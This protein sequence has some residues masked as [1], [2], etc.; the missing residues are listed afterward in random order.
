MIDEFLS[1]INK[2]YHEESIYRSIIITENEEEAIEILNDL[3]QQDYTIKL[4]LNKIIHC[5]YNN[6]NERI[7]IIPINL[8]KILIK[9]IDKL[10]GGI[11]N[12]SYN[13]I[14][15]SYNIKKN[16]LKENSDWYKNMI[17]SKPIILEKNVTR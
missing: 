2:I 5:D 10:N 6:I 3:E 7:I 11:D 4:L 13:F 9:Y 1:D 8:F 14:A 17:K 15:F 16:T 12:S